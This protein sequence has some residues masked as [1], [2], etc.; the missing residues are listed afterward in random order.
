MIGICTIAIQHF[1]KQL[2]SVKT[3]QWGESHKCMHYKEVR[4][5]YPG[6]TAIW[7]CWR[8]H[9]LNSENMYWFLLIWNP[10]QLWGVTSLP[11]LSPPAAHS[12]PLMDL[13]FLLYHDFEKRWWHI[14]HIFGT[15]V[16]FGCC[17]ANTSRHTLLN[18]LYSPAHTFTLHAFCKDSNNAKML[19]VKSEMFHF[20]FPTISSRGTQ[21]W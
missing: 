11:D 15:S 2:S 5:H 17:L 8:G 16:L 3:T 20:N 1:K 7:S 12:L 19:K 4:G 9:Y 18:C 6:Y 21:H 10:L 13:P 14:H